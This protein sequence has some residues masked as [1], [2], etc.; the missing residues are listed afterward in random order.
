[1]VNKTL[2]KLTLNTDF[3]STGRQ[4]LASIVIADA[5]NLKDT[6][7]MPACLISRS[8]IKSTTLTNPIYDEATNSLTIMT[9][10]SEPG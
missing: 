6:V 9:A 2:Q 1:M 8:G 3:I 4:E 5:E 7:N 10:G